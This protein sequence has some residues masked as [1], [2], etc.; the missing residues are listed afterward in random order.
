MTSPNLFK[1]FTLLALFSIPVISKADQNLAPESF[2]TETAKKIA[3]S[4]G[5]ASD[6]EAALLKE[7]NNNRRTSLF[8]KQELH[9]FSKVHFT[10]L[11][12]KDW[13]LA[14]NQYTKSDAKEAKDLA[15]FHLNELD[16]YCK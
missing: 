1:F 6:F 3:V 14:N 9:Y 7:I 16:K 5:N 2:K 12:Y 8:C 10:S 15:V 11:T 4:L 13:A